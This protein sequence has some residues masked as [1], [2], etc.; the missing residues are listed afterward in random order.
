MLLMID[1]DDRRPQRF[2]SFLY[3]LSKP[4]KMRGFLPPL[5]AAVRGHPRKKRVSLRVQSI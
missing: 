1:H 3:P 4:R 5:S 2:A